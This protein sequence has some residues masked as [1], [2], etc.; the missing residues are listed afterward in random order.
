MSRGCLRTQNPFGPLSRR[1]KELAGRASVLAM[2]RSRSSFETLSTICDFVRYCNKTLCRCLGL[3][4]GERLHGLAHPHHF[5]AILCNRCAVR[6]K[7]YRARA[8]TR[9]SRSPTLRMCSSG[10][11]MTDSYFGVGNE[12]SMR[13]MYWQSPQGSPARE[14]LS[15]RYDILITW[16]RIPD[17]DAPRRK[18]GLVPHA[19]LSPSRA[20]RIH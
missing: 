16:V 17:L 13:S 18:L 12:V 8:F 9:A 11:I 19:L 7:E 15:H 20:S 1:R 10:K 4:L 14:S 5:Y 3:G 2:R 6:N